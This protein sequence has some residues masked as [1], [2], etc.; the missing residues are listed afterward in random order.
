MKKVF[1]LV[2]FALFISESIAQVRS[3]EDIQTYIKGKE[4][5]F[6]RAIEKEAKKVCTRNNFKFIGNTT[7]DIVGVEPPEY[8]IIEGIVVYE[9][10]NCGLVECKYTSKYI[11]V[12]DVMVCFYMETP[13]CV[14]KIPILTSKEFTLEKIDNCD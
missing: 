12:N 13:I 5:E 14:G 7:I 10:D 1:I 8:Y 6:K 4:K 3:M 11:F 9:S 2:I